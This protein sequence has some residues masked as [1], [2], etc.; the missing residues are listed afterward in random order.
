MWQKIDA[1][2]RAVVE[3]DAGGALDLREQQIGLVPQPADPRCAGGARLEPGHPRFI[4]E[5]PGDV[6]DQ[7]IIAGPSSAPA[8]SMGAARPILPRRTWK[9]K[10]QC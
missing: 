10:S 1:D 3:G 6:G 8:A 4:L 2:G 7:A 5:R 9:R